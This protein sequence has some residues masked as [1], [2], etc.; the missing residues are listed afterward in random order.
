MVRAGRTKLL[1]QA[2][3]KK[4]WGRCSLT[5]LIHLPSVLQI[6]RSRCVTLSFQKMK[7]SQG[8][9]VNAVVERSITALEKTVQE[10]QITAGGRKR[11][12]AAYVSFLMK[13]ARKDG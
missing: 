2:E 8:F 3:Y 11:L 7:Y 4:V 6:L 9:Q 1:G 12:A 13:K 10:G 5:S